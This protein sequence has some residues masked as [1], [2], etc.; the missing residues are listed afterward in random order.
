MTGTRLGNEAEIKH[1]ALQRSKHVAAEI[2]KKKKA[3]LP[4]R[5][6]GRARCCSGAGGVVGRN[7]HSRKGGRGS[8]VRVW[9]EVEAKGGRVRLCGVWCGVVSA[10]GG[11]C[12]EVSWPADWSNG[13]VTFRSGGR[14]GE[15]QPDGSNGS[16]G[17]NGNSP[18]P[19][20]PN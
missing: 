14:W 2:S 7:L 12:A 1:G 13:R 15:E 5:E 17:S 8:K 19:L 11:R 18:Y 6:F 3:V 16:N 9:Q 4:M 20:L 10:I